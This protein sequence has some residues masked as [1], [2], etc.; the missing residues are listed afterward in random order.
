MP[1]FSLGEPEWD[2]VFTNYRKYTVSFGDGDDDDDKTSFKV[3]VFERVEH[4]LKWR[5]LF[6]DLVR[7]KNLNA[8][9]KFANANLLVSGDAARIN[10]KSEISC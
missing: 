10:I 3:P 7:Q 4:A 9:A 5:I 1:K 2:K 8:Q 6:Q